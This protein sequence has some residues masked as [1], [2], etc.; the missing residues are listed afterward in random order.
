MPVYRADRESL[1]RQSDIP[2][3][4]RSITLALLDPRQA[5]S[6]IR[7]EEQADEAHAVSGCE[8][9]D[10]RPFRFLQVSGIEHDRT[11]LG[12][13]TLRGAGELTIDT[14]RDIGPIGGFRQGDGF[15]GAEERLRT[16]S[17]RIMTAPGE[18]SIIPA[19][20]RA[21]TDFPVP[22]NPPI[23]TSRGGLGAMRRPARSK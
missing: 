17:E 13:D 16:T 6:E 10:F 5:R 3:C 2:C 22:D 18:G 4:I 12:E 8:M 20:P 7:R 11:A 19:S 21:S 14:L 9:C 15:S 1:L 23:A